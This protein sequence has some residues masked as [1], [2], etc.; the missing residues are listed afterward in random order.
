MLF[1]YPSFLGR[2]EQDES[3]LLFNSVR[4]ALQT[5]IREIWYDIQFGT[6]IRDLLKKGIDALVMAEIQQDIEDN[7]MKYFKNDIKLKTLDAW[8]E[9]DKIKVNLTY[10]ELRTGKHNTVQTEQKF[11][12]NDTSLYY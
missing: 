8:Q 5:N 10:I 7:L 2:V 6:H 1:N 9:L 4:M 11:I 3:R 12:N